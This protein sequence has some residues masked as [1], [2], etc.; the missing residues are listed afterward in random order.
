MAHDIGIAIAPEWVN[1]IAPPGIYLVPFEPCENLIDL[2]VAFR[3]SGNY[4]TVKRFTDTVRTT[5]I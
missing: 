4:E 5:T 2:Y 1:N 3:K